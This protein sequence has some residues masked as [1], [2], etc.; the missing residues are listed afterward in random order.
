MSSKIQTGNI[1]LKDG[2]EINLR[3]VKA[4]DAKD[5]L[6]HLIIT[7]SEAY[8][9]MNQ[10]ADAWK[11]M[12]IEKETEIL[13]DFETSASKFMIVATFEN[14]I[15]GGLGFMASPGQFHQK[16]G[17]LGM[18]IQKQ[19][20]NSGLGTQMMNLAINTARNMK[21]HRM[22]LSVRTYNEAGIALYEKVGFE[23]I[24]LLKEVAFIDD[25]FVDEFSYQLILK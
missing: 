3:S 8:Q 5:M 4:E 20:S 1:Q 21:F 23:R 2:R 15:I 10:T 19:F 12:S 9:N 13:K 7:H 11:T 24:G 18:S 14:K 22:E 17:S 6:E 16:S 25:Q